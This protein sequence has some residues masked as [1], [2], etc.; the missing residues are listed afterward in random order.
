MQETWIQSLGQEDP[1]GRKWQLTPVF[2]PGKFHEQSSL[3]GYSPWG[4][5]GLDMTEHAHI[6]FWQNFL[7][8]KSDY[9]RLGKPS[10]KISYAVLKMYKLAYISRNF[11]KNSK[12]FFIRNA[13]NLLY[14]RALNFVNLYF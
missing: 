12:K 5:K 9:L 2:V 1:W 13:E 6:R 11:K 10:D 4:C 7:F 3:A 8:L 14:L